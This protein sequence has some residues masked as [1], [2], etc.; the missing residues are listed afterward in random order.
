VRPAPEG[1][2]ELLDAYSRAVV[3]V[4]ESVGPAVVSL[5]VGG[6]HGGGAGSGVLVTPDGYLL[7]NSHVVHRARALRVT[8]TDGR[9]VSGRVVGDDPATDL[10]LVHADAGSLPFAALDETGAVRPGQLGIAI[11]N[12]LGFQSTVTAGVVSAVGRSLPGRDGRLIEDVVQHTAPLNPGSSGGPL[13]DSRGRVIGVNTA[14]IP[15]AQGIGFAIPA[16]TAGWVLPRLLADGRVRRCWLGIA[17]QTRPLEPWL[18]RR[19]ALADPRAVE[20][21]AVTPGSPAERAGLRE[22]D[23]ILAL[24]GECTPA[25]GVLHRMLANWPS[26]R[27]GR[28]SVLRG[29]ERLELEVSPVEHA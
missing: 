10:A 7:T 24:A 3:R 12:P 11:G 2:A 16:A 21:V 15:F 14:I 18:A 22:G 13:V 1:D 5:A 8:F 25:V 9:S 19:L 20:V 4:V 6:R 17:G 23:L 26:G 27:A 29:E 28:A